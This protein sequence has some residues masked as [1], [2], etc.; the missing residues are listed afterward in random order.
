[1]ANAT[2]KTLKELN[3]LGKRLGLDKLTIKD[4]G[5]VELPKNFDKKVLKE[6]GL[7]QEQIEHLQN[8][9]TD[10]GLTMYLHAG[11]KFGELRNEGS[12]LKEISY[13]YGI[14]HTRFTGRIEA[15]NPTINHIQEDSE[16]WNQRSD[17]VSS[18]VADVFESI[19]A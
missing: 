11:R 10:V 12:E 18:V 16:L 15:E 14:G 13:N 5:E 9:Q 3:A 8:L 17:V 1:M 7:S 2:E 6:S 4:S 19:S